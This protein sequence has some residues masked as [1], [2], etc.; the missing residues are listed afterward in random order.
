MGKS[1]WPIQKHK[2]IPFRFN[3][4]GAKNSKQG[5][6]QAYKS[7]NLLDINSKKGIYHFGMDFRSCCSRIHISFHISYTGD[8]TG[9]KFAGLPCYLLRR[10]AAVPKS[11]P[12]GGF[13]NF[14]FCHAKLC[15]TCD[16]L[17]LLNTN[18]YHSTLTLNISRVF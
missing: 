2:D 9:C 4:F 17:D 1:E 6:W 5:V 18:V 16:R 12:C 11:S 3:D 10:L 13:C 8:N 14:L 15:G 7:N